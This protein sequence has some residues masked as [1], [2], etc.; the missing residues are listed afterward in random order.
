VVEDGGLGRPGR[1][2]V[3]VRCDGVDELDAEPEVEPAAGREALERAI[4]GHVLDGAELM[5]TYER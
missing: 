5:G 3:V 2:E 4:E 1:A